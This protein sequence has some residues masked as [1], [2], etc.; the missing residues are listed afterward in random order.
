MHYILHT[1]FNCFSCY[2]KIKLSYKLCYKRN[3]WNSG[4]IFCLHHNIKGKERR[5][6]QKITY[7][8]GLLKCQ[9]WPLWRTI[10]SESETK[11]IIPCKLG[12]SNFIYNKQL[13]NSLTVSCSQCVSIPLGF[14]ILSLHWLTVH[15]TVTFKH[16]QLELLFLWIN[17]A[18][19]SVCMETWWWKRPITEKA[20]VL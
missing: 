9:H 14:G 5:N 8:K 12:T 7:I 1:Y 18:M 17:I 13:L 16:V 20:H 6:I 11:F 15:I 19:I 3:F 4:E 10:F 2:F